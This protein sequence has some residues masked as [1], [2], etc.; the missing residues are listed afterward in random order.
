MESAY[1]RL[2]VERGLVMED[3]ALRAAFD[4]VT[5]EVHPDAGGER[6]E[7]A[8]VREAYDALRSPGRRLRHWLETAGV[9]WEAGGF[10]GAFR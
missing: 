2:G 3:E 6:E 8:R 5:G 10:G 4:E 7:F 1:E 9:A